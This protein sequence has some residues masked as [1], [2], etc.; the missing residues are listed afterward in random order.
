MLSAWSKSRL[1]GR[2]FFDAYT[3]NRFTGSLIIIDP[4]NNLTVG[5]GMISRSAAQHRV[6]SAYVEQNAGKVTVGERLGRY[7]HASAIL[8]VGPRGALAE[9]VERRLFDRGYAVAIA[10]SENAA[11]ILQSAG[12]I[13]ILAGGL[14]ASLPAGD[15]EAVDHIIRLL[16]REENE[17]KP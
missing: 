8:S 7:G 12:L 13:A 5:A 14:E 11:R 6:R 1:P 2:F 4:S 10:D 9:L 17:C 3:E 15:R 16:E